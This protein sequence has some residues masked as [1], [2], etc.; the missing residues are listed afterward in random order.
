MTTQRPTLV[1]I[2]GAWHL[3]PTWDL[4]PGELEARGYAGRAV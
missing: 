2:P 3:P 4:L 1:L